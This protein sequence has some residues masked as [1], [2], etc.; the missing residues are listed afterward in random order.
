[1]HVT[2]LFCP[3]LK[4]KGAGGMRGKGAWE[5]RT[6]LISPKNSTRERED[7]LYA[8]SSVLR[9]LYQTLTN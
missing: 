7:R 6:S 4:E 9:C 1:M 2:R 8:H 5:C 3:P